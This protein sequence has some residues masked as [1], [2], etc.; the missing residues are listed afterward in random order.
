MDRVSDV[1]LLAS[2]AQELGRQ[3]VVYLDGHT[4]NTQ[5]F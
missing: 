3:M 1:R 5:I 2:T 4:C